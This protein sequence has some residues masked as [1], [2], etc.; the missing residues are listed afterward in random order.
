[1]AAAEA[2]KYTAIKGE[3]ENSGLLLHHKW[4]SYSINEISQ[5]K[6]EPV[7]N[8][9]NQLLRSQLGYVKSTN[10]KQCVQHLI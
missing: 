8:M 1:M 4:T 2:V 10:T 5:S 7:V 3:Q 6:T 9:E